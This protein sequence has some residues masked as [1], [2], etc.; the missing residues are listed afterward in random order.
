MEDSSKVLIGIGAAI[1]I[2]AIVIAATRWYKGLSSE[3]KEKLDAFII[4]S[5]IKGMTV[6]GADGDMKDVNPSN[7]AMKK[8][9][10]ISYQYAK[11]HNLIDNI[12]KLITEA[13]LQKLLST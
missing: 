9:R 12:A 8:G 6:K 1:G 10:K 5:I 7:E 3:N 4:D 2:T 11:E 13:P